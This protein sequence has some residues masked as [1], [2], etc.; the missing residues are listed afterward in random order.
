M[1]VMPYARFQR[2]III[3]WTDLF[4]YFHQFD[5]TIT[6]V[7]AVSIA[8]RVY[9]IIVYEKREKQSTFT[10]NNLLVDKSA[11]NPLHDICEW[12]ERKALCTRCNVHVLAHEILFMNFVVLCIPYSMLVFVFVFVILLLLVPYQK[13]IKLWNSF[14]WFWNW[15]RN[16][17]HIKIQWN[18]QRWRHNFPS[19]HLL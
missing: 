2:H 19:N 17:Y 6:P 5:F 18:E 11:L 12:A 13:C 16:D 4:C 14:L 15:N 9:F 8:V 10:R 3:L 7:F 1:S